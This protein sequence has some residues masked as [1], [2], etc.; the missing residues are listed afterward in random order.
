[1]MRILHLLG[2][3]PDFQTQR[4]VLLLSGG[5]GDEFSFTQRTIGHDG[6]YRNT[7]AAVIGLGMRPEAF[8]LI[9]AWDDRALQATMLAFGQG[10]VFSPIQ[11]PSPTSL[12]WL[13]LAITQREL[14]VVCA[15]AA[16]Q[17]GLE[18]VGIRNEYL[19]LIRPGI[20]PGHA[21]IRR[22]RSLRRALGFADDDYVLLPAGESTRAAG[23][24]DAVWAASILHVLDPRYRVLLWG[25]GDQTPRLERLAEK[26]RQPG[27]LVNAQRALGRRVEFEELLGAADV[28][29]H[30]PSAIGP[31]LPIATAIA[32]GLP[33][34][35]WGS[36]ALA[37]CLGAAASI[38]I[39]SPPS[40]RLL[41]QR[42]LKIRENPELGRGI[43]HAAGVEVRKAYSSDRFVE[44][45]GSLYRSMGVA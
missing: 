3:A 18:T 34:V 33:T 21:R 17:R 28:A 9:H 11:R 44:Q 25:Q 20:D 14:R 30:T 29:L 22:D 45:Y 31:E 43:A 23:H 26:L 19:S 37:E 40:A 1:M 5:A 2:H 10:V 32:A 38:A 35:L 12:A 13:R 4:G 16:Q 41:A 39:V 24:R 42:V 15:T 27:L 7:L 36:G 8:D 6:T